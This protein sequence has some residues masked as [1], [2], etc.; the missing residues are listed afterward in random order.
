MPCKALGKYFPNGVTMVELFQMF[1]D[2]AAAEKWFIDVR[3]PDG[4]HCP[5]CGSTNVQAGAKHNTMPF[6][7]RNYKEC[8]KK[9]SVKTATVMAGSNLGYQIWAMATYLLTTSSISVSSMKLHRDLGITQSAAWHLAH[10][11]RK[12]FEDDYQNFSGS[13]EADES[14]FGGLEKNK[15]WDNKLNAGR[16]TACK[17]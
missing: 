11:I 14:D 16:D 12:S 10:R 15:H 13:V 9:F 3:W 17:S 8:G 6:R 7:C 5:T 4:V 2:D 1:P